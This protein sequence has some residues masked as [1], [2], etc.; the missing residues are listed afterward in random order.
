MLKSM[1]KKIFIILPQ[2]FCLSKH[3]SIPLKPVL[4]HQICDVV[5]I[6]NETE[7]AVFIF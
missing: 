3:V 2:I 6:L 1:G 7:S 5:N 4:A